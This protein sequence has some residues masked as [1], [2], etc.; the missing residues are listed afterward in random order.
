MHKMNYW[1]YPFGMDHFTHFCTEQ[2]FLYLS[3]SRF[4]CTDWQSSGN[5]K[6]PW[7]RKYETASIHNMMGIGKLPAYRKGGWFKS[8]N[9]LCFEHVQFQILAWSNLFIICV[10]IQMW[11][12]LE[13]TGPMYTNSLCK[14]MLCA[15]SIFISPPIYFKFSPINAVLKTHIL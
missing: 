1:S 5:S 11:A 10:R 6:A 7:E 15:Q 13:C 12:V 4:A 9:Q 2:N 8:M 3:F 14:H